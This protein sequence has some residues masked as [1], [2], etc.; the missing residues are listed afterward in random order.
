MGIK[1]GSGKDSPELGGLIDEII[2]DAYGDDEQLWAFRQVFADNVVMPAEAF[3]VRKPVMVLA[4]DY[5]GNERRGLTARC[6]REDGS[7]QVITACDL[8]FPEGSV[9]A[10]YVA[11]YRRWVDNGAVSLSKTRRWPPKATGDTSTTVPLSGACMA[12]AS[13][14]GVLAGSKRQRRS[15]LACSGS[16]L[17]T[18]RVCASCLARS[19][20]KRFGMNRLEAT[21]VTRK[22]E[23]RPA[24]QEG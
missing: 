12:T 17:P 14:C 22:V 13:V 15:L 7:E 10:R 18:T 8:I 16:I 21:F 19:E 11:A 5:D 20:R 24:K 23:D 6:Q 4:L 9:A 1:H 2:V 3:V